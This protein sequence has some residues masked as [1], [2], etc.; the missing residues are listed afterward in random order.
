MKGEW[1][2]GRH[3]TLI[4]H[5]AVKWTWS[6]GSFPKHSAD[7]HMF[8][9]SQQGRELWTSTNDKKQ[10]KPEL[11]IPQNLQHQQL[12]DGNALTLQGDGFSQTEG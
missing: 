8:Q 10:S 5:R 12:S 1:G 11:L 9:E 2:G 6:E 7:N 4:R 3:G